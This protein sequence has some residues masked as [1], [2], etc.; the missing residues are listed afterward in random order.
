MAMQDE[1]PH[2]GLNLTATS[3]NLRRNLFTRSIVT[4]N[5]TST[6][7]VPYTCMLQLGVKPY[8]YPFN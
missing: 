7:L 5:C 3:T 6:L 8:S 2:K 1:N 4:V